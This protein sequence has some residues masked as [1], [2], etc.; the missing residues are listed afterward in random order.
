MLALPGFVEWAVGCTDRRKTWRLRRHARIARG[1]AEDIA[2][3]LAGDPANWILRTEADGPTSLS[4]DEFVAF[5]AFV[6]EEANAD[7]DD[8]WDYVEAVLGG[9]SD[10]LPEVEFRGITSQ[11]PPEYDRLLVET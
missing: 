7:E 8:A 4:V 6:A 11:F 2:D 10:V 1:E 5:V 9:L 3:H